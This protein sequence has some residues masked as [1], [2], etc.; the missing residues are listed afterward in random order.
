MREHVFIS[1][2]HEDADWLKRLQTVLKPLIRKRTV[3]VWDDTRIAVGQKW[4]TE[5]KEALDAAKVAVLLVS[6]DFL[7]SEF[8][9]EHELPG[10]L[11]AA[12][13]EGLTIVWVPVR[14]CLYAETEIADY[15]AASDPSRPLASLTAA[16]VDRALVE[17]SR[18]IKRVTQATATPAPVEAEPAAE[19]PP[20][21]PAPRKKRAKPAPAPPPEETPS[22]D[23]TTAEPDAVGPPSIG[24][25]PHAPGLQQLFPG[26]WHVQ[27]Q[28]PIPGV[29]AQMQLQVMPNAAFQGQLQSPL[30][31]TVVSGQWQVNPLMN[32]IVLQGQ[33]SNGFQVQPY[34]VI[35]Q[36]TNVT[37]Q[38]ITAVSSAGEQVTFTRVGPA[39]V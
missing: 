6:P 14:D 33:Q 19:P 5:I 2:S 17:I 15:Q 1:Y 27:I 29:M 12:A 4:R 26:M 22:E 23:E 18:V 3:D 10:L 39:P 32:Q 24:S 38:L 34:I 13:S 21:P 9:G 7:A 30:G 31:A 37:P 16:E 28:F 25:A 36:L 35:L 11:K 20:P 8:I